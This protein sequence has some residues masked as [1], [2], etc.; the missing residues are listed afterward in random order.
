MYEHFEFLLNFNNFLE[1][2]TDVST[3]K[4]IR[5]LSAHILVIVFELKVPAEGK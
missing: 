2:I 3:T 4:I 1:I 5:L